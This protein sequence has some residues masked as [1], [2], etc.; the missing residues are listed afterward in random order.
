MT[1]PKMLSPARFPR[2]RLARWL[3]LVILLSLSGATLFSDSFIEGLRAQA[4]AKAKAKAKEKAKDLTTAA[5]AKVDALTKPADKGAPPQ[6]E[7]AAPAP[8]PPPP[9]PPAV[10]APAEAKPKDRKDPVLD[11]PAFHRL[12]DAVL[13][14]GYT[15]FLQ[16]HQGQPPYHY[17]LDSGH[18]PDG[19]VLEADG[20]ITG[21]PS[22]LGKFDF[23]VKMTD[24]LQEVALRDYR[25]GVGK[26]KTPGV[27]TPKPVPVPISSIGKGDAEVL[28]PPRTATITVYR[29]LPDVLTQ[30]LPAEP[31]KDQPA[32]DE[33]P[34]PTDPALPALPVL[35]GNGGALDLDE[36]QAAQLKD[37][38]A[39]ML[40]VE[41]PGRQLF[42]AALDAQICAYARTLIQTAARKAG[43]P[44]LTP[45]QLAVVRAP[46]WAALA[47]KGRGLGAKTPATAATDQ[48]PLDQISSTLMT[49]QVRE[50]LVAQAAQAH[51]LVYSKPVLWTGDGTGT[52]LDALTGKIYGFYPLW[53]A[54]DKPQRVDFSLLHRI[55]LF[56]FSFEAD[57]K[58]GSPDLWT[59]ELVA[60]MAEADRHL[61]QVDFTLFRNEWSFLRSLAKTDQALLVQKLSQNTRNL[62]D[63]PIPGFL[64]RMRAFL[65]FFGDRAHFGSGL[66]LWLEPPTEPALR[67]LFDDF[68][69]QL[70]AGLIQ[71]LGKG[72][73]AYTLNLVIPD[74]VFGQPGCF[75][76]KSLLALLKSTDPGHRASGPGA[77]LGEP[78]SANLTLR[79]IVPLSEPVNASEKRLRALVE[80]SEGIDGSGCHVLLRR[81]LPMLFSTGSDPAELLDNLTY[82]ED[83]FGGVAFWPVPAQLEAGSAS[84]RNSLLTT[85][86]PPEVTPPSGL[87]RWVAEHRWPLRVLFDALLLLAVF[88][89]LLLLALS[90][91][92]SRLGRPV[93]LGLLGGLLLLVL[94]AGLLLSGDPGLTELREGNSLLWIL[95][96][97]LGLGALFSVLKRRVEKP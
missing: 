27:V 17:Q 69:P 95:I 87:L 42:E 63:R 57:G 58:V 72:E 74:A 2:L 70:V 14:A 97:V 51:P 90:Y 83:N 30:L 26:P 45:K 47:K 55:S 64:A 20:R 19:F 9:A 46:D 79:F 3:G 31:S 66:T 61:T 44:E 94:V 22:K 24:A 49:F 32:A 76:A 92:V 52:A 78:T 88:V 84:L 8:L 80:N 91:Q 39:S 15:H 82:L 85:F 36:I 7:A 13:G 89:L 60:F 35:A 28:L 65:P 33:A 53:G 11:P 50:W 12:P 1:K 43:K 40:D 41:Y 48:I 56:G 62:I 73:R 75:E 23:S 6:A 81:I 34:A 5:G 54:Q 86:C 29:L 37:L 16:G 67:Q 18:L 77:L 10:P 38:L 96:G 93:Q 68:Y 4:A 71:E 59:P 21:T 25:L